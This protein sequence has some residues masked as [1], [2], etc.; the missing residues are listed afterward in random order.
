VQTERMSDRAVRRASRDELMDVRRVARAA[1][2]A[3]P[4]ADTTA[5]SAWDECDADRCFVSIERDEIVA[6]GTA[7]SLAISLP[8]G[9]SIPAAGISDVAVLP[10]HRR[11]GHQ[12]SIMHALLTDAI[13]RGEPTAILTASDARLYGR[14]GFGVGSYR[15]EVA[16]DRRMLSW[17]DAVDWSVSLELIDLTRSA[18]GVTVPDAV[19]ACFEVVQ[20]R[21]P[22]V[23]ARPDAWW[24]EQWPSPPWI[25]GPSSR[26]VL[27]RRGDNCVGYAGYRAHRAHVE[28]EELV[29][30]DGAA[31][32]ALWR[33]VAGLELIDR[34]VAPRVPVDAVLALLVDD[35]RAVEHKGRRDDVWLC[36]LDVAR[37]LSARGYA[38]DGT[39]TFAVRGGSGA[40]D[41][42]Y[43][44]S[45]RNGVGTCERVDG[46]VDLELDAPDLASLVT[47]A[48][49]LPALMY[50]GRARV[51]DD[52]VIGRAAQM[53]ATDVAPWGIT[54]F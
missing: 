27:A 32:G 19:K 37:V 10:T 52:A 33:Y 6:T 34:I 22:G 12:R 47:G 8:G 38:R 30:I 48:V 3:P 9:T 13:E 21:R 54:Q 16:F 31:E 39:V 43:R 53:F 4:A 40:T 11:R 36:I 18:S 49:T 26:V 25:P 51:I 45:V 41:G 42:S 14:Y 35:L 44:L 23:V 1:F 50:A 5:G 7:K 28:V 24:A 2:L 29:A 46:P 15:E 17:R 20:R